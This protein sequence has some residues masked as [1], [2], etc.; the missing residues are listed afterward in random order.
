MAVL[1]YFKIKEEM[2]IFLR[3]SD[4]FSVTTRGVTTT[5]NSGT[6]TANTSYLIAVT[7]IRNIRSITVDATPLTYGLDYQTDYYYNDAGTRKCKITLTTAQTGDF[8]ITYDYGTDRIFPDFPQS[9]L[10][11]NDFPRIVVDLISVETLEGGMGNVHR[12]KIFFTTI[13]YSTSKTE[14]LNLMTSVRTK[15]INNIT[16]F[17]YVGR[18]IRPISTGPMIVNDKGSNKVF[19][20]NIDFEAPLN[21][22]IN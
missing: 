22:E 13:I 19:Q 18:W 6:W 2:V 9:N 16:S 1:D 17:Y 8:V 11:I 5:T 20:Q 21:Y 10:T 14:I 12:N 4:V 15:Y 3:N 7:N